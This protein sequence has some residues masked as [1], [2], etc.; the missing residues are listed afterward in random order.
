MKLKISLISNEHIVLPKEFNIYIQALIYN[1]LDKLPAD[2]LHTKGFKVEKRQFKLFTFSSFLEK[3]HYSPKNAT[4]TFPNIV[5]FYI[6]SPATWILE[7]FAKNIVVN[8]KINIGK[9]PLNVL[10]LEV[11]KNELITDQKIRV[12][13]LTPIEVHSTLI[14]GDGKKK[15]Y[16]YSPSE[17]EYNELINNNLR[18]KWMAFHNQECPYNIN[19]SPVNIK[20]CQ[21]RIRSFKGIVI[22]G[23]TGHFYLEG[24]PEFLQ[25][26]FMT[27]LG[28]RNSMGF[29]FI[30]KVMDRLK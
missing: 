28:S 15:T 22:K 3:A 16:Y 21:E 8:E 20:Y 23:W 17:S 11:F 12:N 19:I 6:T 30:E 2:W 13:A 18:K 29:G 10:S 26:A 9:K 7:Q 24:P 4:F 25:F 14:K 1:L 5:S 27:G